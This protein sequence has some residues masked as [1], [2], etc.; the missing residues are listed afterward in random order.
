MSEVPSGCW[1]TR[2]SRHTL[3]KSVVGPAD[4]VASRSP[5]D[6]AR[7]ATTAWGHEVQHRQGGNA[8]ADALSRASGVEGGGGLL[9]GKWSLQQSGGS[10][11]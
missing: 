7:G 8:R 3:S 1:S 5:P 10:G 4:A 9:N 6:A 11:P 2:W